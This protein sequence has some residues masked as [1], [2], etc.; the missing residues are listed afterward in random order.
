MLQK[1]AIKYGKLPS[2]KTLRSYDKR[3][4]CPTFRTGRHLC[5]QCHGKALISQGRAGPAAGRALRQRLASLRR[6]AEGRPG[7]CTGKRGT[8]GRSEPPLLQPFRAA[9]F[10]HAAAPRR[11]AGPYLTD[12][13]HLQTP[14]QEGGRRRGLAHLPGY[15]GSLSA[16]RPAA[17]QVQQPAQDGCV[18]GFRRG[19]R[20]QTR[21]RSGR[22]GRPLRRQSPGGRH[23]GCDRKGGDRRPVP[24]QPLPA[25]AGHWVREGRRPAQG[26][27]RRGL[28]PRSLH[29]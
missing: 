5:P 24:G 13:A 18:G 23:G 7:T 9:G 4:S 15:G 19:C 2:A 1:H 10:C 28:A 6:E 3:Q 26:Q 22:A 17:L 14:C 25:A 29:R 12:E 8:G 11:A 20:A 27:P 16:A 21:R